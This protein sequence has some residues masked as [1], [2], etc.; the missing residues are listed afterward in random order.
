VNDWIAS[1]DI[2]ERPDPY[3][4]NRATRFLLWCSGSDP[5]LLETRVEYYRAAGLG[6]F[7]LII[8][9]LA[10][11]TFGLYATV[12]AG[13]FQLWFIPFAFGWGVIVFF[14]DRS[15]VVDPSYGDLTRAEGRF[16][17]SGPGVRS[18]WPP[19]DAPQAAASSGGDGWR[20]A[21]HSGRF[22]GPARLLMYTARLGMALIVALLI[23]EVIVLL[24]FQPEI[25]KEL[26]A[27]G[28]SAYQGTLLVLANAEIAAVSGE[29]ADKQQTITGL[30]ARITEAATD[31]NAALKAYNDEMSGAGGTKSYGNGPVAKALREVYEQ[32]RAFHQVLVDERN[33]MR[34]QVAELVKLSGELAI[35]GKEPYE[36]LKLTDEARDADQLRQGVAG[37]LAQERAFRSFQDKH[38][39]EVAVIV[40]P[41]LIRGLLLLI[42]LLP[43]SL[44]LGTAHTVYG[45]RLRDRAYRLRYADLSLHDARLDDIRHATQLHAYHVALATRLRYDSAEGYRRRRTD[46]L[47]RDARPR[48]EKQ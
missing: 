47:H 38:R 17:M 12:V 32:K 43:L 33:R 2:A 7:I 46:H 28:Q 44:K 26:K 27:Q 13:L 23:A 36:R 4:P 39:D 31:M 15:I 16:P 14:V 37:W 25:Q 34:E 29:I 40:I 18:P 9:A 20:R 41:W 10:A 3:R 35:P 6:I 30:D 19:P 24:I 42:D 1:N 8:A 48:E 22:G 11:V 5:T 21:A 45:R